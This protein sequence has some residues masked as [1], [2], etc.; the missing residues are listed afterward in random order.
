MLNGSPKAATRLEPL[1]LTLADQSARQASPG[2]AAGLRLEVVCLLMDD[3]RTA[4]D[5]VLPRTQAQ[6]FT[7]ILAIAAPCCRRSGCR[8][9]QHDGRRLAV[10]HAVKEQG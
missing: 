2:G 10:L 8:G 9:R 1:V 6:P 7:S 3:H 5:A 4:D